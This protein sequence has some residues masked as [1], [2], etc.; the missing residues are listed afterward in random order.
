MRHSPPKVFETPFFSIEE[1]GSPL[2]AERPYYRLTGPDSAIVLLFNHR[3]E[4]LVVRQL[5]PALGEVTVEFPA[6]AI[7]TG[8]EPSAAAKREVFEETGYRSEVFQLGSYFHLMMNRANMRDYVFC[9]LAGE[10][11]P[12]A[13][14]EGIDHEWVSREFLK[15]ASANGDFRQ[16]AGLGI[17]HLVS[18]HLNVDVLRSPTKVLL[19][20]VRKELDGVDRGDC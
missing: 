5:R 17:V 10:R 18:Q 2:D 1:I 3:A 13:V 12:S 6:G 20:L 7:D 9:G 19:D 11:E 15:F 4:V 8:E 14:E 16:L